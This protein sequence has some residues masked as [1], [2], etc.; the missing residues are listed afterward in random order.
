MSVFGGL[1]A[2]DFLSDADTKVSYSKSITRGSM[3]RSKMKPFIATSEM[4]TSSIIRAVKKTAEVG[5]VVGIELEDE[6]V[7][8]G[9][10]GNV[11]FNASSEELKS[12]KQF[13]KIDRFQHKV[14][15][16]QDIVNQRR[17]DKFKARAKQALTDWA[18]MKFDKIAISAFSAD[19][20][21][22]VV[23]GH[24]GDADTTNLVNADV[25]TTA[26]VEEAKARALQ[27]LDS[28]GKATVPP[29]LPIRT[30]QNENLGY[31]EDVE[32]F[33]MLVGTNSARNIKNDENWEA[34][35]REALERGKTNPIFTGALGF[36]DGVLLLDAKTDGPRNSGILKSSSDFAG[37]GNVKTSDLT[38]YA[39]GGGQETEVN[40]FLGANA[41]HIV[42]DEGIQYYD[43][44]DKDDPRRMNAGIDRV[45]GF[46]KTKYDA[47]ANDGILEDSIFDGKD[48]GVIAVVAS[49]GK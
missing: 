25:L 41:G 9:A 16:T 29:L 8:S 36:W 5:T 4:D 24:H 10:V 45:Y 47:S 15:S 37:F 3:K 18:T 32:F 31:Y 35:R 1:S 22:I 14:P 13:V 7:E 48:Y 17:S 49:T 20:T 44:V 40:L 6:L 26:D 34:A 19:C 33:V 2:A 46:A 30:E 21:N 11:D 43:W 23:C 28:E 38:Q 39:G 42:V 27:G 12:I